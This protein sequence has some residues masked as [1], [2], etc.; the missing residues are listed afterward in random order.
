MP[1]VCIFDVNETLLAVAALDPLFARLFGEAA[2]RRE[3]FEQLI[4]SALTSTVTR[5]YVDFGTI[6]GAALAM[7]AARRGVTLP[8]EAPSELATG[9]RSL[10]PHPDV[11]AALVGLRAAGRSP[12]ALTNSTQ[13]VADAQIAHAGLRNYF[14]QVLSADAVRRLKPAA[15]PYQYAAERL[16]VA[17]RDCWLVAAHA[18]DIA[19]ALHAG[20]A[21]AFL[22]R[23]GKVLDPLVPVPPVVGTTLPQVAEQILAREGRFTATQE[24]QE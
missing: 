1:S 24:Q 22:A 7:V 18:W 14:E 9:M 3:W 15:E 8:H 16:G 5:A 17:T 23:P 20:C 12:A 21:T 2:A 11:R 4:Q 10:P 6:G 13:E 19:G